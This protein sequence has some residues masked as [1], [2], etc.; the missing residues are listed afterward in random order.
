M[1]KQKLLIVDKH[2]FGY[3][4]DVY[5]W[6]KYLRTEYDITVL[7]FDTG[8]KKQDLEGVNV[9]YVGY[10]GSVAIRG[11]RFVLLA[12]W[13]IFTFKGIVLVEY[14][15]H[16]IWLK[17]LL[18]FK[19]MI[20]D[21]RTIAVWGTQPDRDKY[22]GEIE[23]ACKKY[24]VVSVISKGVMKR[25]NRTEDDTH[26]LPLGADVISEIDKKIDSLRL[27]YVGTFDGRHIDKTI[28][29]VAEF[30]KA[31]PDIPII[32]DVIGDGHH[33]ELLQ[34]RQLVHNLNLEEIVKLHGR[35]PNTELKPYF[36]KANIGVSFVPVTSYYNIQPPTKTFEYVLSGLYT[37]AT[38]TEENEAVVN[39]DCG[40]L[41]EDTEEDFI[42]ALIH[43][44]LNRNVFN[45][46]NIRKSLEDN[47]W[48]VIVEKR[49][50]EVLD[51]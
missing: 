9:C 31:N 32:Y 35:V 4:I 29:A 1:Q 6:C 41:I 51:K 26:I 17:K 40:Y 16:C 25:L 27:I 18:P 48:N 23:Q 21:V 43:I 7:C 15:E 42:K 8:D 24:D 39:S 47:R 36:D 11:I 38:K 28:K 2:Q 19:K 10:G 46:D 50:K 5:K 34:Y 22:D 20:L 14:F 12:L 3:L 33:D 13:H 37:I 49:L 45:S 44:W 30:R